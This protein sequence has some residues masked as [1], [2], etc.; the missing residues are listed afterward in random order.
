[1][2][3][4]I[5]RGFRASHCISLRLWI[6]KCPHHH[7]H[8][9]HH[10]LILALFSS[11]GSTRETSFPMN[12]PFQPEPTTVLPLR[13]AMSPFHHYAVL[14]LPRM[15]AYIPEGDVHT[16]QKHTSEVTALSGDH[17]GHTSNFI[18][19][20][21]SLSPVSSGSSLSLWV[22]AWVRCHLF[23]EELD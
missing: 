2:G 8:H 17:T 16:F 15:L 13:H 9:R 7:H 18:L 10:P 19:K 23:P 11:S 21:C 3:Y 12:C 1:M 4:Q 14:R 22:E 5:I 20:Y 6:I